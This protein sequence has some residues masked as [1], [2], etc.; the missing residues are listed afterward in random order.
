MTVFVVVVEV[1]PIE[2]HLG[3][4]RSLVEAQ[5]LLNQVL[6]LFDNRCL[7][8]IYRLRFGCRS[9]ELICTQVGKKEVS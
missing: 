8:C 1:D 7:V 3:C 6:E 2:N 9:R 5:T 4:F